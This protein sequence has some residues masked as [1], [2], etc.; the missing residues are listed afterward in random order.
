MQEFDTD[1]TRNH[2]NSG[3]DMGMNT[4]DINPFDLQMSDQ[5]CEEEQLE[6]SGL[7]EEEENMSDVLDE[8]DRV[9]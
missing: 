6:I 7:E 3:D 8:D 4:V 9:C 5:E 2:L 1:Y